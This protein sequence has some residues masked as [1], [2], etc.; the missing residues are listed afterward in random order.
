MPPVSDLARYYD[1]LLEHFGPSNWWPAQ[2]PFEVVLGVVLTQNT[3]WNNVEKALENLRNCGPLTPGFIW[4]MSTA[5]LEAAIRPSGFYTQKSKRLRN[6]LAYLAEKAGQDAPPDDPSLAWLRN[7][8]LPA[9]REE[10]LGI[11]GIG[12]ESAD[13]ILLYALEKPSFVVDAYT[14]RIL[15]RHGFVGEESDYAEMQDLL[16]SA[17]PPDVAIYNEYHALIVRAGKNFCRKSKPLCH[18]CPLKDYLEYDPE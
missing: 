4:G 3:S 15:H 18:A 11:K 17:L 6:V 7:G 1:I 13:S 5:A 9:L 8:D 12:R 14:Y 2:S 10:L 16:T